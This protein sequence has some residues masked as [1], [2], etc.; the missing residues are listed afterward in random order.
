MMF[1]LS[2]NIWK[3]YF[4][5]AILLSFGGMLY[6]RGFHFILTAI[7]FLVGVTVL[8]LGLHSSRLK[9]RKNSMGETLYAKI[10]NDSDSSS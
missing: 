9:P 2:G 5:A 3:S 1:Y 6:S 10:E 8:A 4:A 7:I